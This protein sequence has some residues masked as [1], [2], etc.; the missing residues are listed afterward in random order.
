LLLKKSP[1]PL[2]PDIPVE[3][4]GLHPLLQDFWMVIHPPVVFPGYAAIAVPFAYALAALVKN[5]YEDWTR[6]VLPWVGFT[7]LSLE[8]GIFLGSYWAYKVLG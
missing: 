7:C 2:L 6:L 1:F 4:R 8:A 3:G 5:M